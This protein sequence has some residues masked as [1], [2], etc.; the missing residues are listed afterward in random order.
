MVSEVEEHPGVGVGL[1]NLPSTCGC[2]V[3]LEYIDDVSGGGVV[4]LIVYIAS[5]VNVNSWGASSAWL[6]EQLSW[7][8]VPPASSSIIV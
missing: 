3:T 6:V 5:L 2:G 8:W 7:E 4:S 1:E